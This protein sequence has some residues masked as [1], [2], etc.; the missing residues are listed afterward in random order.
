V[1]LGDAH[2][3]GGDPGAAR[4]CWQAALTIFIDLDHPDAEHARIRM[5]AMRDRR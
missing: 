3:A 4:D 2:D 1:H 5:Q